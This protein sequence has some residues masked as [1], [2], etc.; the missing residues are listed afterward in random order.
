MITMMLDDDH[1]C[2]GV[3]AIPAWWQSNVLIKRETVYYAVGF[4]NK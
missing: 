3:D 1:K 4:V 2:T